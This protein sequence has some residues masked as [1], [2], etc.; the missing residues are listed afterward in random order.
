M[1]GQ[2]DHQHRRPRSLDLMRN[3]SCDFPH[4]PTPRRRPE[5]RKFHLHTFSGLILSAYGFQ[6]NVHAML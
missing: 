6:A 4:R 3:S 1:T 2:I 5:I